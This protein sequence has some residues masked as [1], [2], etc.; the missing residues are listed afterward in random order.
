[1]KLRTVSMTE[2]PKCII[3]GKPG[4]LSILGDK[5]FQTIVDCSKKRE[6]NLHLSFATGG[7]NGVH[8]NC[9]KSYTN[10]RKVERAGEASSQNSSVVSVS[11]CR[12]EHVPDIRGP[13]IGVHE[14]LHI[15]LDDDSNSNIDILDSV[16]QQSQDSTKSA[17]P[18]GDN[19]CMI[20]RREG[21][22]EKLST[23]RQKGLQTII[24]CSKRRGDNLHWSLVA[25][26]EHFIHNSCRTS[27]TNKRNIEKIG[28]ASSLRS[29]PVSVMD[30]FSDVKSDVGNTSVLDDNVGDV[31]IT[32]A[33]HPR[34]SGV[35]LS[36]LG[37]SHT[38]SELILDSNEPK[39]GPK[40]PTECSF[41]WKTH[42]FICDDKIYCRRF[43][44]NV[45]I[46]RVDKNPVVYNKIMHFGKNRNDA[47]ANR[48]LQRVSSVDL[49][50]VGARYHNMCLSSLCICRTEVWHRIRV[51]NS[52]KIVNRRKM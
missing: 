20:C 49:F 11:R 25:D 42:C 44:K 7:V 12:D 1:M 13:V 6:D 18:A 28:N 29:S 46:S 24:Q 16:S 36:Q 38:L 19:T 30:C 9:R 10:K 23:V 4:D 51:I 45:K 34:L 33:V 47:L 32:S 5:D 2:T 43:Q 21:T 35:D 3:C 50:D 15:Q 48:V 37:I 22:T 52:L 31:S 27:Y 17:V 8:A 39:Y 41:T 14:N 40:I 26:A